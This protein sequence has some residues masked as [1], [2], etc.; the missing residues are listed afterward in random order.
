M[1]TALYSDQRIAEG[2]QF[3]VFQYSTG[4]SFL[5]SANDLRQELREVVSKLDP[6]GH[7]PALQQ[8]V[9]VGHSM[10]GLLTKLL[11]SSS[12]NCLWD[13]IS[14]EPFEYVSADEETKSEIEAVMFFEPLPFVRR[15]VYL[16]TP[17]RGSTWADRSM[18]RFARSLIAFPDSVHSR[19]Q[20][21]M[22][23]NSGLL[24]QSSQTIPT[25]LDHLKPNDPI[26]IALQGITTSPDVAAHSIIGIGH[27]TNGHDGDGTVELTSAR[28][29]G[30]TSELFI[31]A[32]HTKIHKTPQ[33]SAE[34]RMILHQHLHQTDLT[35]AR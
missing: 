20:K 18:G 19:Y 17:H 29:E 31:A 25:S 14:A 11:V 9:L 23:N 12:D 21:L 16:A 33:A 15:A 32:G 34:V 35:N 6:D 8:M 24:R 22:S 27:S 3:W 28:I 26:M 7:D 10:G 1:T 30:T 13:A 4:T 5:E 2:Y